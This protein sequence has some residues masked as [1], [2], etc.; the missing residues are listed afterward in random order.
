MIESKDLLIELGTE[1]LPPTALATLSEHFT[2]GII[3]QLDKQK[4]SYEQVESFATP[5]RLAVLIK[6][7]ACKQEDISQSRKGPSVK[8]AFDVDGNPTNAAIG[9]AKS[10]QTTV[11]SLSRDKTDKGEWL[12]FTIQQSGKETSSLIAEIIQ[13]SLDKLPIP[14]RMRWSDLESLFVRPVHWLVV[15]FGNDTINCNLMS[16]DSSNQTFGHRFH[17]PAAITISNPLEYENTLSEQAWVI[18]SFNKRK[19]IVRKQ[20]LDIAEQNNAQAI[21]DEN[22]LD[23]VTGMVEWPVALSGSFDEEFLKV[24]AEALISAMKKHQKY[25]HLLDKDNNLLPIFITVANIESKQINLIVEGNERVIRPRLSDANF[26]WNNDLET[27][28][29][30][31][32]EALKKVVFQN[33]LGTLYDKTQR[34]EAISENIAALLAQDITIAKRA[35][36]LSKTDLMSE[37]IGEFPDLQGIMGRYYALHQGEDNN[38]AIALDEQYLPRF[39]GDNVSSNSYAQILSIADRLDSLFG[40][41]AIGMQPTG[42]KDPFALRRASLGILRTIVENKLDLDLSDLLTEVSSVY[43]EKISSQADISLLLKFIEDR[44]KGYLS[45]RDI[46]V[47]IFDSVSAIKVNN[48]YDFY[49]RVQAVKHFAGLTEAKSLAAAN[50]R[51]SNILKKNQLQSNVSINSD[52]FVEDSESSLFVS[53]T[54]IEAQLDELLKERD[55]NQYLIVLSG[56]HQQ[57]DEFFDNVM[58][59]CDDENLKNNRI[60]LVSSIHSLFIKIADLSLLQ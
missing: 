59:L 55:Y 42:D 39:S 22:L 20:V 15:L 53:I 40:I 50:K 33:K 16:V 6:Q 1:E 19:E 24:P 51:I 34:V 23:E 47:D 49:L 38:V 3:S 31:H 36:Y 35:A 21:I 48:P 37:M 12:S 8:A 45:D 54:A 41:F 56:L 46:A 60:A 10:C 11:E 13:N 32:L 18:A 5:R 58:V 26:F 43:P 4:L 7:L 28:V 57:I 52:L 44:F 27:P 25:F 9:F 2:S 30:T 17:H 14:K 29:E